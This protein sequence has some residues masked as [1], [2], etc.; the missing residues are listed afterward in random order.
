MPCL[1]KRKLVFDKSVAKNCSTEAKLQY[2]MSKTL[3]LVGL[4]G[5]GK[6]AVGTLV[7]ARLGVPFVDSDREMEQAA[8][9]TIAEIFE[10]DG[11]DFFRQKETQ[12]LDRLLNGPPCVL[13]TGGG[14]Y[15]SKVNRE[16][17]SRTGVAVWLRADLD[18]LWDRVKHKNTRPLLHVPDPRAK[19]AELFAARLPFYRQAEISVQS[20]RGLSLEQM[21]SKVVAALVA[22]PQ[23][24]VEEVS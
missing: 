7:A 4:M 23:S 10:H 11:E 16:L 17:I 19:L 5:A 15:L 3:V 22:D 1:G 13:S 8:N 20:E 2:R 18:L 24:G 14:A 21:T 9:R 6:T 12:V